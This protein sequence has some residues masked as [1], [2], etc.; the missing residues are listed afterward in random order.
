[1][2]KNIVLISLVAL[3]TFF[4]A[5]CSTVNKTTRE[6]KTDL[7]AYTVR[8]LQSKMYTESAP[9]WAEMLRHKEGCL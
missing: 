8:D 5:S 3:A 2:K 1:M 6:Q 9:E 4:L 7:S